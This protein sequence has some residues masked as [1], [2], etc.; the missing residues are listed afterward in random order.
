M[1]LSTTHLEFSPQ[2]SMQAL[3]HFLSWQTLL[4]GQSELVVHS[5]QL[6]GNPLKFDKQEQIGLLELTRQLE[7]GPHGEGM[8]GSVIIN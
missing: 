7:L 8:Q 5:R 2:G 3:T 1:W 6:G 4:D